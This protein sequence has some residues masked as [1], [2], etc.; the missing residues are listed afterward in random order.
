[1]N[2]RY[3][4]G[5]VGTIFLLIF[6]SGTAFSAMGGPMDGGKSPHTEDGWF[7]SDMMMQGIEMRRGAGM[8]GMGF[9][10]SGAGM[11]G[12]YITFDVDNETGAITS[13]GIAGIDIFDSIEVDGFDYDATWV[14]GAVTHVMDVDGTTMVGVHDNPAA[15]ITIRSVDDYTVNFDLADDVTASEEGN[16][17]VIQATDIEMYIVCSDGACDVTV[18]DGVVSID[19]A[20]NSAVVVRAI[21]VNMQSSGKMHMAFAR[22]MAQ[23]RAGAEICLGRDGSISV[24]DYSQRMQVQMQSMTNE[25][26]QLRVNS[27]DPEGKIMAFNLDNTSLILQERDML[28]IYYDGEP[29]QC[30]DDPDK[31]FNA[32]Q[33]RC[34]ISL[35]SRERAQIM[36]YIPE[37]SEHTIDIVVES[38]DAGN[39]IED[40]IGDGEVAESTPSTGMPGFGAVMG[41]FALMLGWMKYQKGKQ[42]K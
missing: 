10:H 26:I 29:M 41:I 17:V 5:T 14:N 37:F 39:G 32:T 6:L 23:N 21:P 33:A 40:G 30:V 19:A 8:H 20:G 31:V 13:Y 12:Q 42:Y 28:R 9:M 34:Y 18:A 2:L 4:I 11:Y 24:V 22:E 35:E 25:R 36:M 15:V 7:A 27:T 1:M 16:I 38:E 3:V